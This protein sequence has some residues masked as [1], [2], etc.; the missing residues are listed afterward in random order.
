MSDIKT[1]ERGEPDRIWLQIYGDADP[2]DYPGQMPW[3]GEET[4]WCGEPVF[5]HDIEYVR[6]DIADQLRARVAELEAENKR[7]RIAGQ[8]SALLIYESRIY[9]YE[10]YADS[11]LLEAARVVS[12]SSGFDPNQDFEALRNEAQRMGLYGRDG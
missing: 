1:N 10:I 2:R 6:S 5:E 3:I 4:S 8:Y 9:K 11:P 7:L 12:N